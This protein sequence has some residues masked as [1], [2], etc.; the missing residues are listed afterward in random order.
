MNIF[1]LKYVLLVIEKLFF[2]I[3]KLMDYLMIIRYNCVRFEF[4]F[5]LSFGIFGE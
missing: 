2:K 4:N 3:F 5:F 1:F